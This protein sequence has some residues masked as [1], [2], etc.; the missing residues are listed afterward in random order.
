MES[1]EQLADYKIPF[2]THVRCLLKEYLDNTG[3]IC[4]RFNQNMLGI[5]W[6]CG[7][8]KRNNLTLRISDSVK[9][10]MLKSMMIL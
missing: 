3:A 5:D 1:T 9:A 8:I 4:K 10:V 7:F 6:V 2:G